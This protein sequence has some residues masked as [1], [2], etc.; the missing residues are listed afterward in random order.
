MPVSSN[1]IYDV[2][3]SD[4]KEN[5]WNS[6]FSALGLYTPLILW[7]LITLFPFWYMLVLSTRPMQE[8]FSYPPPLAFKANF[9]QGFIN[10][11]NNLLKQIP[12]WH[13]L[14]NSFYIATM[15]TLLSSFFVS[16]GGFGFG[17]YTF[18]GKNFFF[19]FMLFTMMI[20]QVVSI[21]P[22]FIMMKAFGWL[23]TAKALYIPGIANAM[24]IFLMTQYIKSSIP[25][26]II[27]AARI[28]GSSEFGI[29]WRIIFPLIT[30]ALGS[31]GIITFLGSWNNYMGALVVLRDL[32]SFTIPVALG[33]LKGMQSVDFGAIMVATVISV[34]PLLLIFILFSRL[35]ITKVT[36]GSMKF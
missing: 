20:P 1:A 24:G 30:P 9:I 32:D 2:M 12:F 13:N 33:T 35:I 16:L 19:A 27:D 25:M 29:F 7:T 22:F 23:N 15:S 31:Y 26:E 34:V 8:I 10:N 5:K 11:Y 28:D 4:R 3:A 18:K 14:W 17:M 6:L 36:E 21:I